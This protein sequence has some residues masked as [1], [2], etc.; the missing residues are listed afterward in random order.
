MKYDKEVERLGEGICSAGRWNLELQRLGEP[1]SP[2]W[3][4]SR[5]EVGINGRV[6]ISLHQ[7][8]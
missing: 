8:H 2:Q 6:F 3:P 1:W 5:D 4:S 7:R